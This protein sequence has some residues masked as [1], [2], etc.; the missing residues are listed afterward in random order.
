MLFINSLIEDNHRKILIFLLFSGLILRI[1]FLSCTGTGPH[2]E[3]PVGMDEVNYLE[4]AS[5]I[6]EFKTYGAWSE[7]FYTRS[8]RS[9]VYP[10]IL[11]AT[12]LFTGD[13]AFAAQILNLILDLGNIALIY[14]LASILFGRKTALLSS[15]LWAFYAPAFLYCQFITSD[16]LSVFLFL[17]F[18]VSLSLTK[19]SYATGMLLAIPAG[20]LMIHVKP[21]FLLAIPFVSLSVF[22]FLKGESTRKR[23]LKSGIPLISI[24]LLCIPWQI[25][26]YGIH[27]SFVPVCTVAGWHLYDA[28]LDA[29][30]LD[31]KPLMAFIYSKERAGFTETQYYNEGMPV[32]RQ[33]LIKNPVKMPLYGLLRLLH[34]WLPEKPYIRIFLPYAYFMPLRSDGN[35]MLVL[36]D[37]EGFTYCF[38][39]AFAFSI[40]LTG[41]KLWKEQ[42]SEWFSS[43]REIILICAVYLLSYS[44]GFPMIQYRFVAEPVMIVL[45]TGLIIRLMSYEKISFQLKSTFLCL[46]G[47]LIISFALILFSIFYRTVTPR[48]DYHK[49]SRSNSDFSSVH[50]FQRLNNGKIPEN[51]VISETGTVKYLRQNLKFKE[52]ESVAQR[53]MEFSAAKLYVRLYDVE[54]PN[55]IGDLKLNFIYGNMPKNGD[56]I[57]VEGKAFPGLY[58]DIIINVDHWTYIQNE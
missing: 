38:L 5:N 57:K 49:K 46:S 21:A 47:I 19:R 27:K 10:A 25:R 53:D 24:Y 1:Y 56:I 29:K 6:V 18:C 9:P 54:W 55:G 52:N 35:I 30:Q 2:Y 26:N 13:T 51:T 28:V 7:S 17:T 37:F 14:L 33:K 50:T 20:A 41:R 12:R 15:G 36:P 44:F 23:L 39:I 31:P 40:F 16:I 58:R 32:F 3:Y 8:T 48:I 11:S 45:G 42:V 34:S 4:L 22:M 43:C